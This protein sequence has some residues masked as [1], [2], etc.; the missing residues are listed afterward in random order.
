VRTGGRGLSKHTAST[1]LSGTVCVS[2]KHDVSVWCIVP[3]S[4]L[5]HIPVGYDRT[6]GSDYVTSLLNK[7][8]PPTPRIACVLARLACFM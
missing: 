1:D 2:T 4:G 7:V 3:P 6:V 5:A 8:I